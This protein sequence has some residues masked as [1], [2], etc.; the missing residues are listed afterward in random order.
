MDNAGFI[1]STVGPEHPK[2]FKSKTQQLTAALQLMTV[3]RSCLVATVS[4][5][6]NPDTG[7]GFMVV[8][9]RFGIAVYVNQTIFPKAIRDPP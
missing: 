2:F 4:K 1:S 3:G 6:L 5:T 9:V 7:S 8:F